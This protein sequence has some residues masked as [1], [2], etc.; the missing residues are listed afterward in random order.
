MKKLLLTLAVVAVAV[1]TA[2]AEEKTAAVVSTEN[3]QLV[4]DEN[5]TQV[6][7]V[8]KA[9]AAI[10]D[11]EGNT[12]GLAELAAGT[13]VKVEYTVTPEGANEASAVSAVKEAT[14]EEAPAE[15]AAEPEEAKE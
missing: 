12:V 10:T 1:M 2:Y 5:G 15:A 8:L 13:Q 4:V 6:S 14:E 3:N 7:F 11:A 9:D